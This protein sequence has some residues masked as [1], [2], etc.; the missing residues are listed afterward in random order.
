MDTKETS[1]E[2]HTITSAGV[3]WLTAT[4]YRS[5][6]H[7]PFYDEA[8]R[9]LEACASLGNEVTTW[10]ANGYHGRRAAGVAVGV[11]SDTWIARLSSDDAR[12][13]WRTLYPHASNVSRFD[14]Q[15]TFRLTRQD[16]TF[17]ERQRA[18]ALASTKRRGRRSNVTLI[19]SS[20][21]GDS[22]YLGQRT[23]DIYARCYDKGRE[24]KSE[25]A[26]MVVRQELEYKRD[27]AKDAAAHLYQSTSD[28]IESGR[29]VSTFFKSFAVQTMK[30]DEGFAVGARGRATTDSL[31]LA[32]L[33]RAVAPSIKVLLAQGKL[34]EVLRALEL[35]EY[36][37]PRSVGSDG[38]SK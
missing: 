10:K 28:A 22:L 19:T 37:Q 36:V 13:S 31:R 25:P 29:L 12:E 30:V 27:R 1:A 35:D 20:L 34:R 17:F 11:R 24:E 15:V 32:W 23:S 33:G 18:L 5:P 26:G 6:A 2:P 14:V 7:R 8:N 9:L 4:A 38:H 21:S 16:V 3:D